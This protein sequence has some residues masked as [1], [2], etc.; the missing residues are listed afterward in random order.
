M[1]IRSFAELIAAAVVIASVGACGGTS[2]TTRE[3]ETTRPPDTATSEPDAGTTTPDAAPVPDPEQAKA[4]LMAAEL[5]AY[6]SAKPVFTAACGGCHAA[7]S[8]LATAKKLEHLDVTGYPFKSRHLVSL[9]A[10]LRHV[11]GIDG[12][13]PTM[14]KQKPG[15]VQGAD[16]AL[17]EAWA[18]AFDAA[19]AGGAH[20]GKPGY[21]Q[22]GDV[23]PPDDDE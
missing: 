6:E 20:L 8:K 10:T 13:K 16:L 9:T 14:P 1:H 17:V 2:K 12:A 7:G 5:S 22:P 4:A 15:S 19:E 21:A 3:S 23:E 11:L 18:K